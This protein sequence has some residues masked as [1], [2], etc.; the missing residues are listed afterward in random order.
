MTPGKAS[1]SIRRRLSDNTGMPICAIP[2]CGRKT[3]RAAGVGLAA[4]HCRRHVDH[5]ARHGS[6]WHGTYRAADLK[7]YLAAA[8]SFLRPKLETDH[9][10]RAAVSAVRY[11]MDD[12][13]PAEIAT[14]LRGVSAARRARIALARLRVADVPPERFLAIVLA[15]TALIEEDPGSHRVR[16][17]PGSDCKG[18]APPCER[19]P[20]RLGGPRPSRPAG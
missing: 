11:L 8:T 18:I 20:S 2:G 17:S 3:M 1:Y 13:G 19:L 10:I 16:S 4:F 12:A 6:H 7:P 14:R 5:K 15:V 9:F